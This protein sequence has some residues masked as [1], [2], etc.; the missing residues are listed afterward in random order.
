M[1]IENTQKRVDSKKTVLVTIVAGV[2]V[3]IALIWWTKQAQAPQQAQ[4]SPTPDPEV[5]SINQ[6]IE[7]IN[8]SNLNAEL[9]AI[10]NELQGL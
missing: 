8:V 2:V 1:E 6:E 3:L 4:I 10:D 9:E 5:A 7:T